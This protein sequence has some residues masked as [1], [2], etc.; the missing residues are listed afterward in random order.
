MFKK[1]LTLTGLLA[2]NSLRANDVDLSVV[3]TTNDLAT[4]INNQVS[5]R[6]A[7]TNAQSQS[8]PQTITFHPALAGQTVV[9]T[10][11][12][13][14][15]FGPSALLVT[16]SVAID[17]GTN[18]IVIRQSIG[19]TSP[20]GGMRLFYITTNGILM[21]RNLT[22]SGGLA[23]GESTTGGSGGG[24]GLGGAVLNAG[25][26]KL[27]QCTLTANR[28]IGGN[29]GG[30]TSS[31]GG[32]LGGLPANGG[33]GGGGQAYLAGNSV[34]GDGGFGAGGGG[35]QIGGNGG[36]GGGC[37]AGLDGAGLQGFGAG[38]SINNGGSAGAGLGGAVFN[39]GGTMTLT[40]STIAGNWAQGGNGASGFGGAIFNLNGRLGAVNATIASNTA[41]QGGGAIYSLGDNGIATQS[42]PPLVHQ[43]ATLS[44]KNTILAG[45][46]DADGKPVSDF[47]Q[48]TYDSSFSGNVGTVG[49][50]GDHN[51][52]VS[53]AVN[54]S[55]AGSIV[56]SNNPLL[57]P[58]ANN[59][60]P[61]P[62]MAL[63]SGSPALALGDII[64]IANYSVTTDQRG[65]GYLRVANGTV[66]I[67][68]FQTQPPPPETASLVVTITNDVVNPNDHLTSLREALAYAQTL[69]GTPT[70]TF[71][72]TL[73]GQ[74]ILLTNIGDG[75]FGP[76]ALLVSNQTVTI[77]GGTNGIVISQGIGAN[78]LTG[79]MRL[80]YI[81]SNGN[82]TLKNLTLSGGL[83][84]GGNSYIGGGAAGLGGAVV[85]A[86]V[87]QVV[88]STLTANQARGGSSGILGTG[89]GGGGGLGGGDGLQSLFGYGGGPNGGLPSTQNG[90]G[91]FGGGGGALSYVANGG[92]GGGGGGGNGVN[93]ALGGFGG[94]GGYASLAGYGGF[95]GGDKGSNVG[96][97]GAGFGGAVFNYG[98]TVLVTNSTLAGN[99]AQGGIVHLL[100]AV[101]IANANLIRN[102]SQVGGAGAG[103]GMGGA[104]F[105][106]NGRVAMLNT[107][108][109]SNTAPQGGG[110]IYS[111]GD[112]GIDTQSGP[113]LPATALPAN[114]ASIILNNTI[115]AGS[116]DGAGNRVSDFIQNL[117]DSGNGGGNGYVTSGGGSNLIVSNGVNYPFEGGIIVSNNPLLGSLANNGGPTPTMA[118]LSGS[119]A[120]GAGSLLPIAIGA[121]FYDQRGLG[122]PRLANYKVSVGAFE[123]QNLTTPPMITS[124]ASATFQTTSSGN[125]TF[126]ATGTPTPLLS[127][128]G[129]LPSGVTFSGGQLAGAP[130]AG[131]AGVYPLT[132]TA[133]NGVNPNATQN[134]TLYVAG[135]PSLLVTTTNDAAYQNEN[136]LRAALAYAQT[137]GGTP[138]I[139]F[140]NTLAGQT[141]LLT[142][143]GDGTFGPSALLVSN[144]TVTIDGGTNGIVISQG[145]GTNSPTGGMRLF[146]VSSSG[147]LTLKSLTLSGGL[148]QGGGSPAGG[149]GAAGLG[150]AAVN[151]GVLQVVQ[152]TLTA[153]QAQG[154][155][156]GT[157]V[158]LANFGGGGGLGGMTSTNGSGGLPNGGTGNASGGVGGFG[159]GGGG[160]ASAAGAGGFGGGGG[161]GD[162]F[163]AVGGFG[164]GGGG[165]GVTGASGGFGGGAGGNDSYKSGGGAG[166]GGALFN[167][168]GVLLITNS[169]FAANAA[170]G[171]SGFKYGSGFGGA[172]FN[173]NGS[174]NV[175]NATIASNTASADGGGIYSVGDNGIATQNGPPLPP[176]AA[177]ITLN[178]TI[179]FGSTD[180][181]GD[182]IS[183][184]FERQN[185]SGNGGGSGSVT[186]SGDNNLIGINGDGDF[187]GNYIDGLNPLLG[188]L[189]NNGGPTPTMVLLPGSPAKSFGNSTAAAG[190]TTDQ[191]GLGY[192][193]VVNGAVDLGAYE[194]QTSP[195]QITSATNTIFGIGS[196]GNFTFTI[197]GTP[198]PGI[199]AAGLLPNGVTFNG[200]QLTGT[201]AAGTA[202]YYPLVITATNGLSPNA[203]Q[204]FTLFVSEASSLVVTTTNDVVNPYDGQTS[205]RE[206]LAYAQIL[207]G[208]PTIT[209]TNT[210]AGQTILLTS[211]GDG[212]FGP[213]ALLVTNVVMI[214]GG[215]NGIVLS[216]NVGTNSPT[217]GMRL[218]YITSTG[219]LTMKNLTVSGGLA[220]GGSTLG[221][222]GAGAGLG[223]AVVNAGVLDLVQC[224]LTGNQAIGG[225][226]GGGVSS[227]GGGLGGIVSGGGFGSGG[228]YEI[229]GG[230][231]GFGAG[232]GAGAA[233]AGRGGFGG[234]GGGGLPPGLGGFAGGSGYSFSGGTGAGLGGAVFNYGGT[235][236]VTN[237]TLAGNLARA[238]IVPVNTNRVVANFLQTDVIRKGSG[239]GGA[240]FNLN[241]SVIT[242]NTTIA[243]NTA[244]QGGGAIYNLGDNGVA[245]QD[246]PTLATNVASVSL[247]NTILAGSSD[248]AG[249][250][251]SDYLQNTNNSGNGGGFGFVT[252]SGGYN[253][254]VSNAVNQAFAGGIIS[255]N[256]PLL[257]TLA[258]NGGSTPTMALLSGSP[259]FASG[260]L[261]L[262]AGL[263]TDQRG[264]GYPR[265]V[266]GQVS[267]GAYALLTV[268]TTT[269]LVATSN[270]S[271]FGQTVLFTAT[272]SGGQGFPSGTV[273]FY[274][275]IT[276]FGSG[277]LT[278]GLVSLTN[279]NLT[280]GSHVIQ[281]I[282]AGNGYYL[283]STGLVSQTVLS[284]TN[285]SEV[286]TPSLVVTNGTW[287]RQTSLMRQYLIL[288]NVTSQ[289]L[290]G[291]RVTVQLSAADLAAHIVLYNASGTNGNGQSYLQYNYPVPPGGTLTLAAEFY[292]PNRVSTP[293]PTYTVALVSP[294]Q[295]TAPAGTP[296]SILRNPVVL[297][298]GTFLIDFLTV[299][300]ASYYILYSQNMVDWNVAQPP[301][302]GTG[303][304]LQWVDDGPP[305][306]MSSP[307][308][309][310]SRYYKVIKAN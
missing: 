113:A 44:L 159:G 230:N 190:L 266:N 15:T 76:S 165:G 218:F 250:L 71:T 170:Q 138:I 3:T 153:N 139:T 176:N 19:S 69:G 186:S 294:V 59:G 226:S 292:S 276:N 135:T 304:D 61:T 103:S 171:G 50:Y 17:G 123:P 74:T 164:G 302:I 263:T 98:G 36:F 77:D 84:Q 284:L 85:N 70:I 117:N 262:A 309:V 109:A 217:G 160:N 141:I 297:A 268:P 267:L 259:A 246:G 163:G 204:Y 133:S 213:S 280:V 283:A 26:F 242:L 157:N 252:S 137:L 28:A 49:S 161:L 38:R 247:N 285:T 175:L 29:C 177:S 108:V 207:G 183:D 201:P 212:T 35:G 25:V 202:G 180:G 100:D 124:A 6:V 278:N 142:N 63:L 147:N 13:D 134:F 57:G 110:A 206:A 179:L 104:I 79:G 66:D 221:V 112:N 145:I 150:G 291:V 289:T 308:S 53:N 216:Q 205:L 23:Q 32:G 54:Y 40:N 288:T 181:L 193:R 152:C 240:I 119:P 55:Y 95:G 58:L 236:L 228:S 269:T 293:H 265:V 281:A 232:G 258:N 68:A 82:L 65:T 41:P 223:G 245:T 310:P 257:G 67:G 31:S 184:Y 271:F 45:S 305:K 51:L 130:A 116:T 168:G 162:I 125:F 194:D 235:V 118:L 222:S 21:L 220:Q 306:T 92:F 105:N 11:I 16:N 243:S 185:N 18:G 106:L 303:Y 56:A 274:D 136:S 128:S 166:L 20:T 22:L 93:V 60:G 144:E 275:G 298:D 197:S 34:G 14:G 8:S 227:S 107:T 229:T 238:G 75:T 279:A 83:A 172:I 203:T 4:V 46:T 241:G 47:I 151:A 273:N 200:S 198:A 253:L 43:S 260:S 39:Y 254:I 94:G 88:Q 121:I 64:V 237:S 231:G 86:G 154:G 37:G 12:G 80:F 2:C 282:F 192:L 143:I 129:A 62:T 244:P 156:G 295:L 209:F 102:P 111:L 287:F 219:N 122:Y 115:L 173:L 148:A 215:T 199:N 96:G 290:T 81:A 248:G 182:F 272:V 140:T 211:I 296:Q 73:A 97:G 255:S 169:T 196:A 90:I 277:T 187:T 189:T 214:D 1:I 300:G 234:G 233:A 52:I 174:V 155:A 7:L 42:G 132:I 78:S 33:F 101:V 249:N 301:V 99:L 24:A 27:S 286:W 264:V 10:N 91:G 114:A 120:I 149:G 131:T 72:N 158:G 178:N 48:N 5:L 146:Y 210:L 30:G 87:L 251:V 224:T 195:P 256:S 127:L 9:L 188:P 239:F 225:N 191:R 167:Y 126:I 307:S 89:P 299:K 270:P 208:T 261:T